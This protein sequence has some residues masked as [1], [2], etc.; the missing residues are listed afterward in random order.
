[1][2]SL[3]AWEAWERCG[4]KARDTRLNRD[5]AL[6]FSK[7]QFSERFE[8]E[9]R[10]VAALNHPNI[11]H[12]YDVA[13]SP[14]GF[15]YLVMEL[16]EGD[17][18]SGPLPLE[19]AVDYARQIAEAIEAAHEKGIVHRDLKPAN[20][21]ITPNGTVKVLDFGLAKALQEDVPSPPTQ[22][23]PTLSMAMTRAGMILGTAAYMSPEQAKG[24]TAD[25]RAAGVRVD[26]GQESHRVCIE[27]RRPSE[28]VR[29]FA[30]RPLDSV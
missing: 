30:G 11:C 13:T 18:L 6:K 21:K 27:S 9:A 20:I 7:D 25:R 19:T 4:K 12:L 17:N 15:G 14:E 23:S 28:P 5:V 29:L 2:S 24:K 10:A 3:S 8:R 26:A 1:L 16:V 22:D